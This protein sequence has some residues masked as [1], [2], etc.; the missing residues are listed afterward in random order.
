[1]FLPSYWCQYERVV[2]FFN[3]AHSDYEY[4]EA[5]HRV[6]VK[7]QNTLNYFTSS[8]SIQELMAVEGMAT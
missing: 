3:T 6:S 5:T 8:I 7:E 4:A 1:M 2:L